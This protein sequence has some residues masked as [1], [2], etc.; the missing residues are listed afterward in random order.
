MLLFLLIAGFASAIQ[1]VSGIECYMCHGIIARAPICGTYCDD[2]VDVNKCGE[3]LDLTQ[4]QNTT[5]CDGVCQ[6]KSTYHMDEKIYVDRS[7][8]PKCEEDCFLTFGTGACF[9][10]CDSNHCNAANGKAASVWLLGMAA[11]ATTAALKWLL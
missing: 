1:S 11:I 5:T 10:C 9:S 6:T 3:A 8:V 2:V 7:C 4:P